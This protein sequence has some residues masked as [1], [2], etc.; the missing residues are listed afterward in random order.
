MKTKILEKKVNI[1]T[2]VRK[3]L[4]LNYKIKQAIKIQRWWRMYLATKNK[5]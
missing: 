4:E 5:S 1:F 3:E 2:E